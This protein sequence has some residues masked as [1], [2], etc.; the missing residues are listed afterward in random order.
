[1]DKKNIEILIYQ[2]FFFVSNIGRN[3]NI[4]NKDNDELN[5]F[6]KTYQKMVYE[7]I[8]QSKISPKKYI[9]AKNYIEDLTEKEMFLIFKFLI[10][11]TKQV[12]N[13]YTINQ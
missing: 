5:F 2:S 4:D 11:T 8:K 9:N 10:N 3:I 13:I 7:L 12:K 6:Y 1:M